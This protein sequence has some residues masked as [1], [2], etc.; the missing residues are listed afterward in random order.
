MRVRVG[1]SAF[2][3]LSASERRFWHILDISEGGLAFRYLPHLGL[4]EKD[5]ELEIVTRDTAFSLENVPF[6]TVS[7][8]L[9]EGAPGTYPQLRRRSVQFGGLTE[10]QAN[11][12]GRF[13]D[14]YT[15][16]PA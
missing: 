5:S 7:D 14:R 10:Q 9:M 16:A 11:R 3:S 1:D 6:R 12:L 15:L 8:R 4:A 13:I 2:V